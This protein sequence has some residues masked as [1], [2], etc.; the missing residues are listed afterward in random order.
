MYFEISL[1]FSEISMVFMMFECKHSLPSLCQR[2]AGY[3]WIK[4]T[5][6]I[7]LI[8]VFRTINPNKKIKCMLMVLF[9]HIYIRGMQYKVVKNLMGGFCVFSFL[10]FHTI[11]QINVYCFFSLLRYLLGVTEE[12]RQKRREE[13]LSTR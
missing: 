8:N 7:K 2:A 6:S 4:I 9:F 1:R 3:L 5:T 12:E 11:L 13:I 10:L